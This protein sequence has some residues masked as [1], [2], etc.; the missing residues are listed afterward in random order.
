[1]TNTQAPTNDPVTPG[2]GGLPRVRLAAP[3][4]AQAEIYLQGAHVTSWRPS[5]GVERLFLSAKADFRPGAALRGGVPVIFPQFSSLGPLTKHGFA[6]TA[7]WGFVSFET[8]ADSATAWF[9]L[10]DSEATRQLWPHAF[11][12]EL[13]V[14]VG[15]PRLEV[16]LG[17]TNTGEQPFAFT[18]ALHTYLRV[19]D[20]QAVAIDNLAGVHFIDQRQDGEHVQAEPELEFRGEVDRLYLNAPDQVVVREPDR[21]TRVEK[22]GF[23]D[24]VIWNPGAELGAKLV[25]L[26]PEG[27]RRMVC[28][29]SAAAGAPVR[30]EPSA[31]WRAAQRV[32]AA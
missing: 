16:A 22:V 23:P 20:I 29:E 24:C 32:W 15:G 5:G 11:L 12:A 9:Q 7:P 17:V 2:A 8:E 21:I 26:E 14:T 28:V 27:Y 19:A 6:R 10:R 4:G 30:L 18:A 3:D 31:R 13:S 25:D 1:M